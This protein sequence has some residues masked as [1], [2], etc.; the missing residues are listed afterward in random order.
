MFSLGYFLEKAIF[1]EETTKYSLGANRA[2]DN[3]FLSQIMRWNFLIEL[4][5]QNTRCF[6]RKLRFFLVWEYIRLF[7]RLTPKIHIQPF[8]PQNRSWIFFLLCYSFKK[9]V[10][11]EK[12]AENILERH[13]FLYIYSSTGSKFSINNGAHP[14]MDP[15]QPWRSQKLQPVWRDLNN[16][17]LKVG[18]HQN[19]NMNAACENN[20]YVHVG[21][22]V[23]CLAFAEAANRPYIKVL[24]ANSLWCTDSRRIAFSASPQEYV[25]IEHSHRFRMPFLRSVCVPM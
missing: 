18:L 9:A 7:F 13:I 17:P 1:S 15:Q 2:S 5:C 19:A 6:P 12:T 10:L 24:Y 20:A 3:L 14:Y 8:S 4:I 22:F 23:D 21:K 25:C 11:F 16:G